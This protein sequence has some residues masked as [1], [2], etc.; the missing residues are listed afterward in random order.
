MPAYYDISTNFTSNASAGAV[1][2]SPHVRLL[3]HTTN[4]AQIKGLYAGARSGTA[5]GGQIRLITASTAMSSCGTG[6][7][8]TKRNPSSA[9]AVTSAATAC[10]CTG[11]TTVVRTSVGVAQ[12]GGMGGWVAIEPDAAVLLLPAAGANG[13]AEI[14]SFFNA[15]SIAFDLT[16]EFSE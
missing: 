11:A 3:T 1:S 12:T 7:T 16:V 5:G 2:T 9:V 13:N 10:T 8:P 6:F 4:G 14:E 15:S